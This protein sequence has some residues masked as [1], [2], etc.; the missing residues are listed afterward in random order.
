ML[1]SDQLAE[2]IRGVDT[3]TGGDESLRGVRLELLTQAIADA[4]LVQDADFDRQGF[5]L[6]SLVGYQRFVVWLAGEPDETDEK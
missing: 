4:L 6:Y 5:L 1:T 3:G 2:I